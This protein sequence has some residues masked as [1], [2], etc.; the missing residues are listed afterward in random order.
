MAKQTLR[1][2]SAAKWRNRINIE[3]RLIQTKQQTHT[4]SLAQQQEKMGRNVIIDMK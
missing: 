4:R 3:G 2:K 1:R